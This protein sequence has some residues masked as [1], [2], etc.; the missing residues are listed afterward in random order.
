MAL[1]YVKTNG[2]GATTNFAVPFSYLD[3][4]HVHVYV[5]GVEKTFTWVNSATVQISPAPAAGTLNVEIRR[6]TPRNIALVDYNNGSVLFDTDL[7]TAN[8]QSLFIAQ[9]YFEQAESAFPSGHTLDS[10]SDATPGESVAKGSMRVF[11]YQS[12]LRA[13]V[14]S[15]GGLLIGDNNENNGVRFLPKGNN[16]EV[17]VVDDSVFGKLSWK[18]LTTL[19]SA[20]MAS[21]FWSTGDLKPTLKTAA[22]PGW[23]MMNDGSIGS[24]SSGATTRANAD[25]QALYTL[26]WNNVSNTWA[27]V[28]GGRG[29]SA[30]ADF[31][32]NKRMTLPKAL[33]RALASAGAGSGL[34]SRALG[35]TLG[36][37]NA[38][39]VQHN[40]GVTDPGHAHQIRS[41][42]NVAGAAG[43]GNRHTDGAGFNSNTNTNT[44]G[45]TINS[46]GVSGTG[47][48][49]QPTLFIN[50]M[51]KL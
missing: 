21:L 11:D 14:A 50:V 32:A 40:H 34:T 39:V 51:I 30:S 1:S 23:V 33:G 15:D 43:G 36:S 16:A 12:K 17:L 46:A 31:A 19:V 5:G 35:E 3:K 2:D 7:D 42:N 25:T 20:I 49:M 29:A 6:Q 44:T 9:E 27:P 4:T 48:N 18:N 13:V 38:V 26:L 28:N 22:D 41:D 8:L 47:A 24:A 45:I 37:E 10:H